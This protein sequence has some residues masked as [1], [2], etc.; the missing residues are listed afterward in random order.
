MKE[1]KSIR[2]VRI[3]AI[4]HEMKPGDIYACEACRLELKV[5]KACAC[6]TEEEGACTVPLQCCGKDMVK[7]S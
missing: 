2:E 1:L 3:M 6:G 5:E 4:C 7:K